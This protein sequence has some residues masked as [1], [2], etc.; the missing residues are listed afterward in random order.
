M[1][2]FQFAAGIAHVFPKGVLAK[3]AVVTAE[4]DAQGPGYRRLGVAAVG[5]GVL[6][7]IAAHDGPSLFGV[8]TEDGRDGDQ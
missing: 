6:F 3:I 7:R 5:A 4:A 2:R 8:V 1:D